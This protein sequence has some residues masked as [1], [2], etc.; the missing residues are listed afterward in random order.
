MISKIS[1]LIF[2][3][4]AGV[5]SKK[6][7]EL[8][9]QFEGIT[10]PVSRTVTPDQQ[11]ALHDIMEKYFNTSCKQLESENQRLRDLEK[12]HRRLLESRGDIPP[13]RLEKYEA[14][15]ASFTRLKSAV[16]IL[17]ENLGKELPFLKPKEEFDDVKQTIE[18]YSIELGEAEL[19]L[20]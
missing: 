2:L 18:F 15:L 8:S 14:H 5:H 17:A 12:A 19:K 13:D 1:L 11:S 6:M 9:H 7:D 3:I 16:Q 10:L 20:F 4:F